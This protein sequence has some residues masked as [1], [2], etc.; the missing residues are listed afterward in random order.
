LPGWPP[1]S[2]AWPP[3]ERRGWTTRSWPLG[4]PGLGR[5]TGQQLAGDD[6]MQRDVQPRAERLTA[7]DHLLVGAEGVFEFGMQGLDQEGAFVLV[8]GVQQFQ[9]KSLVGPMS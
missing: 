4:L 5:L 8:G 7:G 9:V 6:L 2:P 3:G 1:R